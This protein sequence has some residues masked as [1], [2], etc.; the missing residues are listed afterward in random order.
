[1]AAFRNRAIDT[2]QQKHS[3]VEF[4]DETEPVPSQD[5]GAAT[6]RILVEALEAVDEG[7]VLWDAEDR[8]V[9][10]NDAYRKLFSDRSGLVVAGVRFEDLMRLQLESGALRIGLDRRSDWLERRLSAHRNPKGAVDDEYAD[11]SWVRVIEHK[12]P[13]GYTVG[14][15]TEISQLKRRET[16]LRMVADSNR[17]VAAAVDAM[18]SAILITAPDRP[19]NPTVFANQAFT[20]MTGWPVEEALGRDR[21]FLNGPD[22][23]MEEVVRFE[24]DM[25]AGQP[26]SSELR[27]K[28]RNGRSF[29]VYMNASPIRDSDGRVANWV[30]VQTAIDARKQAVQRA[31][32]SRDARLA[33][34]TAVEAADP[35]AIIRNKLEAALQ[36]GGPMDAETKALLESAL[37][38]ARQAP[39]APRP[40]DRLRPQLPAMNQ[41]QTQFLGFK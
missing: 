17:R 27:L 36:V 18:A 23:D 21:S 12:T 22:T 8:L 39:R 16:A 33:G 14:I 37:E 34:R 9:A 20:A 30:I 6:K 19:G 28:D 40:P 5:N 31:R 10:C 25:C 1:M 7:V 15:C 29:W 13:A 41:L 38:T 4:P 11:G 3:G 2:M 26:T 24:R 32:P 35:V